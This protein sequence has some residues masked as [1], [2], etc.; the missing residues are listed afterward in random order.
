MDSLEGVRVE[1]G[2][3]TDD[4]LPQIAKLGNLKVLAL[5]GQQIT[6]AGLHS[7]QLFLISSGFACGTL[8]RSPIRESACSPPLRGLKHLE[9]TG[10]QIGD[11][12]IERA[13]RIRTIED[14]T[15]QEECVDLTVRSLTPHRAARPEKTAAGFGQPSRRPEV[16]DVIRD[17][18]GLEQSWDCSRRRLT[19]DVLKALPGCISCGFCFWAT[20]P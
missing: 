13:S 6:D 11:A 17:M 18:T 10:P 5:T 8:N 16:L 12:T 4:A 7:L 20:V 19:D 15:V 9:L 14:L 2:I 3:F 1:N